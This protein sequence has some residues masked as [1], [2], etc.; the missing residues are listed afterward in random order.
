MNLHEKTVLLL[1]NMATDYKPLAIESVKRNSHMNDLTGDEVITNDD[2]E[3][4]INGY[5]E[6]AKTIDAN[7]I[8]SQ[9]QFMDY[10]V[11]VAVA[12]RA[13]L[14]NVRPML[15]TV[16]DAVVVDFCNYN[17]LRQGRDFGFYSE[18]LIKE[19]K[20]TAVA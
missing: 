19:A 7:H 5:T 20:K 6:M 13:T 12:V 10:L 18:D 9:S 3:V 11:K 14:T 17:A 8:V 2:V 1:C 4:I 16:I 15:Q